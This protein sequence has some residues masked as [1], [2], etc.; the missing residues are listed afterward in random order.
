MWEDNYQ[1]ACPYPVK[2]TKIWGQGPASAG[3]YGKLKNERKLEDVS[4][5]A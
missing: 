1:D 2:S 4:L 3:I 5:P